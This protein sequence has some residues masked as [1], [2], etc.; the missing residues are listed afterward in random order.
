[1][2][3]KD[4]VAK[5]VRLFMEQQSLDEQIKEIKDEAKESGLNPAI[6][7]TVAKSIVNGKVSELKEKSEEVLETIS[8]AR[9]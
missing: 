6:L 7:T 4:A 5:L 8:D 9:G 3:K 1:M 2:N